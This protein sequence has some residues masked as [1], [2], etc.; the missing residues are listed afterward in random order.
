M[1][2]RTNIKP[3]ASPNEQI[4][5]G[6]KYETLLGV[7]EIINIDAHITN[8]A[9]NGNVKAKFCKK[10]QTLWSIVNLELTKLQVTVVRKDP[11]G[12]N[13]SDQAPA[14]KSTTTLLS[15]ALDWPYSAPSTT[16]T[17]DT[18]IGIEVTKDNKEG[19]EKFV[20][21]DPALFISKVP[22]TFSTSEEEEDLN[23][24]QHQNQIQCTR[25]GVK[26]SGWDPAGGLDYLLWDPYDQIECEICKKGTDDRCILICDEC[27]LGY[28][29]Y[30]L[31]PVVSNIPTD[32]WVCPD[33]SSGET[34]RDGFELLVKDLM[35]N[36][37]QVAS[38]LSLPFSNL[39]E[40]G[41]CHKDVLEFISSTM[42]RS[43]RFVA[44]GCGKN[45]TLTAQVG[46]VHFNRR[47]CKH[48]WLI[49]QLQLQP[50]DSSHSFATMVAAMKYCGVTQYSEELVYAKGVSEDMNDA[51]MDKIQ[52]MSKDNTTI[53]RRYKEN[54]KKGIYPPVEVV[55]DDE[56]GFTVRALCSLPRH[57]I[58]TEYVGEVTTIEKCYETNS[59]S[60][61]ILLETGDP[62]TS[63]IIDPTR[64]SNIARF[65][66][67]V[68]NRSLKSRRKAN[69]RTRRFVVDGK[70]RVALFTSRQIEAGESL[71]YDYNA[72]N[73]GKSVKD[74]LRTGF[75]DTSKFL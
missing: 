19:D 29:T 15:P 45:K 73:E 74:I 43:S 12:I 48:L 21:S 22:L 55:Y 57:T 13:A 33:C 20:V 65:L 47:N 38:F 6:S 63:L 25:P 32:E 72:G 8:K 68:N 56:L 44:F 54:L 41:E 5:M 35:K 64:I 2:D 4:P 26:Q 69:V 66:S 62:K 75:Y 70:S 59:D 36:F 27:N 10:G 11:S 52:K 17:L 30:C 1:Y 51:S 31:R 7:V 42:P 46:G 16:E 39:S 24:D 40:I 28:H 23:P 61:M 50:N 67:G 9:D 58:L 18:K 3:I 49:P 53:F 34:G 60:L 71:N 37:S 14:E